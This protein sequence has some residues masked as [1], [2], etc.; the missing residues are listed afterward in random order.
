MS[1]EQV[2]AKRKEESKV[3]KLKFVSK[4]DREKNTQKEQEKQKADQKKKAEEASKRR[5]DQ[6]NFG[7]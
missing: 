4:G 7:G 2:L 3:P 1:L 5:K 6:E